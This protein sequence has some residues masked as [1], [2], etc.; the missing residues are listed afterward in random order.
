MRNPYDVLGVSRDADQETIRKAYKKLA[1]EYHPDRNKTAGAEEKFKE[2]NGAYD[3]VGDEEKRKLY[4]EFGEAATR[5]GFEADKARAWKAQGGGRGGGPGFGTEGF[6]FDFGDGANMDDILGSLFGQGAAGTRQRRGRDQR[7]TMQIDPMLAI[8]GGETSIVLPRPDGSRETLKVRIP[9]GVKDGGTLRLKG[10]GLPPP[11]G[12]PCGDLHI[13]LH[14]PD[15][16]LLRRLDQDLELDVPITVLEA[17]RGGSITVP[18]PTGD[19]KV[20]V[21]PGVQSGTRLRLKGRGIQS[22][23]PGDLYL[24]LRPTVPASEDPEVIAAAERIERAYASDVRSKL[25]LGRV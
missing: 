12:G 23:T 19:V 21:P 7:A 15:H 25:D 13:T 20:T 22:R 1:R 2:L 10:Q 5:P 8:L 6:G 17:V 9:A 16:P 11:G 3:A 14:V 4:D 18:T 24:V